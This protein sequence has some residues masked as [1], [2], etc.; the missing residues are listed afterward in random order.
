MGYEVGISK[1]KMEMGEPI[2]MSCTLTE[3][4]PGRGDLVEVVLEFLPIILGEVFVEIPGLVHL[5]SP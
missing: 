5:K 4:E 3:I 2:A 1:L